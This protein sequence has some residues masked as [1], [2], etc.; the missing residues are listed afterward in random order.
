[1][2]KRVSVLFLSVLLFAG[3]VIASFGNADHPAPDK[4]INDIRQ[5]HNIWQHP[6]ELSASIE[7]VKLTSIYSEPGSGLPNFFERNVTI[8]INGNA[9][10]LDKIDPSGLIKESEIFDGRRLHRAESRQGKQVEME[11]RAGAAQASATQYETVEFGIKNLGLLAVLNH[12]SNPA[13]EIKYLGLTSRKENKVEVG[14]GV[15]SFILYADRDHKIRKVEVGKYII[16]Y[17][18]YR[19]V[20]GVMLPF[21][22]RVFVRGQ[23]VYEL[24]FTRIAL[25]RAFPAD[26]FSLASLT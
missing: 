24:V 4:L 1:M 11:D 25:D 7:A 21:I 17:A 10:R 16:E 2:N 23:L 3:L 14:V 13:A 20:E 6:K 18:G 22:Q 15:G 19:S 5:A 8:S 12:L 9:V 26:Y